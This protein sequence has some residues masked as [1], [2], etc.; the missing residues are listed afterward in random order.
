MEETNNEKDF[1]PSLDSILNKEGKLKSSLYNRCIDVWTRR[2]PNKLAV[3]LKNNIKLILIYPHDI[4]YKYN[5]DLN[6]I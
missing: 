3:A 6:I 1:E 2:D 5:T 4:V